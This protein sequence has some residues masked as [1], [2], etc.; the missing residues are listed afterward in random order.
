MVMKITCMLIKQ[1]CKFKANDNIS[2]YIFCLGSISKDFTND[3]Q[4]EI[5]LN[6]T[7]HN[8]PVDHSSFNKED[9]LNIHQYLMIKNNLK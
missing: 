5:S 7:A 8:F 2:C 1:I 9:I 3:E 4:S 6:A